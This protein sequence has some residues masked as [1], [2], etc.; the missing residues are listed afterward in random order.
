MF[1]GY[2]MY[3]A[4][5]PKF[6]TSGTRIA[7][8]NDDSVFNCCLAIKIRPP[9]Y[10]D[11]SK[12]DFVAACHIHVLEFNFIVGQK[13]YFERDRSTKVCIFDVAKFLCFCFLTVRINLFTLASLS[14]YYK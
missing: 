9:F 10:Y 1:P 4:N 11:Q 3:Q 8:V 13:E 6:A 12:A 14:L 5:K 7:R 2:A